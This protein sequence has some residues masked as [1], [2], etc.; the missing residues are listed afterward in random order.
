M[1]F[2]G[3][4]G[5]IE[6]EVGKIY[7]AMKPVINSVWTASFTVVEE[8]KIYLITYDRDN[9]I[10]YDREAEFYLHVKED[11]KRNI[12]GIRISEDSSSHSTRPSDEFEVVNSRYI[13]SYDGPKTEEL[14]MFPSLKWLA[15][16]TVAKKFGLGENENKNN[17]INNKQKIKR[18]KM[19]HI[20]NFESFL[21]EATLGLRGEKVELDSTQLLDI[22]KG[23]VR[24]QIG[25]DGVIHLLSNPAEFAAAI[26]YVTQD[27]KEGYLILKMFSRVAR[28]EIQNDPVMSASWEA[29]LNIYFEKFGE[30][31]EF[32]D[33]EFYKWTQEVTALTSPAKKRE[34]LTDSISDTEQQIKALQDSLGKMKT[35]LAELK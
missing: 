27:Q 13:F 17:I 26:Q 32:K 10:G 2:Y 14:K 24:T 1:K 5:Q 3:K 22:L 12:I 16:Q 11:D 4:D 9:P 21:N 29:L 25:K 8:E 31:G 19:K 15:T 6:L 23:D 18:I 7:H 30:T 28:K 34:V 20:E 33:S 35:E